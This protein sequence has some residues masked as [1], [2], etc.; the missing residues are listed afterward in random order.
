[1]GVL[2]IGLLG[3]WV[4]T[5]GPRQCKI[6]LR[7]SLPLLV[8]SC[9]LKRNPLN[10]VLGRQSLAALFFMGVTKCGMKKVSQMKGFNFN[11]LQVIMAE[12][13][14]FEPSVRLNTVHSLS[15]RARSTTP[16]PLRENNQLY[17]F[18]SSITSYVSW[19]LRGRN[20]ERAA[21]LGYAGRVG[22]ACVAASGL[23][24]QSRCRFR[25]RRTYANTVD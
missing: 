5:P 11:I 15:R 1:M 25:E 6:K 21:I 17:F 7:L 12:R 24:W 2:F 22:N 19:P 9:V 13:E 20:P 3:Y 18:R 10:S 8:L 4:V 23:R 16:A 14:G